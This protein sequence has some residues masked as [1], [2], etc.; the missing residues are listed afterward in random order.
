[1][2]PQGA[3]VKTRERQ[4][5]GG[6]PSIR[7]L[8]LVP[9]TVTAIW[10]G[11]S[12][13]TYWSLPSIVLLSSKFGY[14]LLLT[15][16]LCLPLTPSGLS[17][18]AFIVAH[19]QSNPRVGSW[20]VLAL[21]WLFPKSSPKWPSPI[22][23]NRVFPRKSWGPLSSP[24]K[25]ALPSLTKHLPSLWQSSPHRPGA[26]KGQSLAFL[27]LSRGLYQFWV[28]WTVISLGHNRNCCI[29]T[30]TGAFPTI[31]YSRTTHAHTKWNT[32]YMCCY[33]NRS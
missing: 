33:E 25:H 23:N 26:H 17:S 16:S 28:F 15:P 19:T 24:T 7:L 8:S 12:C 20:V 6:S 32:Q 30:Q 14:Y 1:M 22:H 3:E 10:G 9:V 11:T 13:R 31:L 4:R 18:D 27:F 21:P 29:L 5:E 2:W